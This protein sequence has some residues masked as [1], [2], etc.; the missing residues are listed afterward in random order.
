MGKV[1]TSNLTYEQF[2][3]IKLLLLPA[4]KG[5]RSPCVCMFS[6]INA[7]FYL[8]VQGCKWRV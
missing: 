3:L 6:V 2:E 1:Y 4:K 7:T 8:A 5:G